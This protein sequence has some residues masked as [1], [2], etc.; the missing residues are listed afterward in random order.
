MEKVKMPKGGTYKCVIMTNGKDIVFR[1][2]HGY[3]HKDVARSAINEEKDLDGYYV[4]GGGRISISEN[5]IR[6][7]GYSV[8]F[9]EMNKDLVGELLSEYAKSNGK[10]LINQSGQGY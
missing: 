10:N 2:G 4:D 3:F 8:D 5:E 9:G 6:V 1:A 7:Y